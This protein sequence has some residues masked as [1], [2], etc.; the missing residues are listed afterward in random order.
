[1][2]KAFPGLHITV[3]G[4]VKNFTEAKKHLSDGLDGVMIGRAAYH[5]PYA[6]L[7]SVDSE[8]FDDE[9][10]PSAL[11]IG[12]IMIHYLEKHLKDGGRLHQVTRHM[13]GL[14][15]GQPGAR[16]WRRRLSDIGSLRDAGMAD[17]FA[18]LEEITSITRFQT[19]LETV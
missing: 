8:I 2:K 12:A 15:A 9:C 6:V 7:A 16:H 1:M 17:Y 10:P 13:F 14:F 3:N 11:E 5:T 18:L 19:E 4:G